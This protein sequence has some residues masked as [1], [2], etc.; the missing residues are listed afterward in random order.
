MTRI[1]G[2]DASGSLIALV[3]P[4]LLLCPL[5]FAQTPTQIADPSLRRGLSRISYRATLDGASISG[6]LEIDVEQSGKAAMLTLGQTNLQALKLMS[7]RT[8]I[9]LASDSQGNLIP[10]ISFDTD[11]I[12]GTF[13]ATGETSGQ[14]TTFAL[15]LPPAEVATLRL[16]TAPTIRVSCSNG[17]VVAESQADTESTWVIYPENPRQLKLSCT[18]SDAMPGEFRPSLQTAMTVDISSGDSGVS[19][20][21]SENGGLPEG[22]LEFALSADCLVLEARA[23][24]TQLD[25]SQDNRRLL[26]TVPDSETSSIVVRARLPLKNG[27]EVTLPF[28]KP[29]AQPGGASPQLRAGQVRLRV[30]P[31]LLVRRID[32]TGLLERDTSLAADGTLTIDM[33]PFEREPSAVI[34]LTAARPV[35]QDA[36]AVLME[37]AEEACL[38]TAW[39]NI[40]PSAGTIGQARWRIPSSW[41][42]TDLKVAG[43]GEP[44]LYR[45]VDTDSQWT[46]LHVI[47]RNP[48]TS[49]TALTLEA[50]LQNADSTA[51][52]S[53]D[54]PSFKND[55]WTRTSDFTGVTETELGRF[56][57][58][59]RPVVQPPVWMASL[60]AGTVAWFD[61]PSDQ[62]SRQRTF[63]GDAL[64]ST[65]NYSASVNSDLLVESLDLELRAG[66]QFPQQLL[67]Q[68]TSSAEIS[69]VPVDGVQPLTVTRGTIDSGV[70]TWNLTVPGE[71]RTQSELTLRMTAS[72]PLSSGRMRATLI[73]VRGAQAAGGIIQVPETSLDYSDPEKLTGSVPYPGQPLTYPLQVARRQG[74]TAAPVVSGMLFA[75]MATD[76]DGACRIESHQE[77][78]VT[79]RKDQAF[80][81]IVIPDADYLAVHVDGHPVDLNHSGGDTMIPLPTGES[82]CRI[83]LT[84]IRNSQ[85]LKT[86]AVT[87][88]LVAGAAGQTLHGLVIPPRGFTLDSTW[89]PTQREDCRAALARLVDDSAAGFRG[90]WNLAAERGGILLT[91]LT[92]PVPLPMHNRLFDA[93]VIAL[94]AMVAF[95]TCWIL[96][97]FLT[98]GLWLSTVSACAFLMLPLPSGWQ[99][100]R[101]GIIGGALVYVC[102]RS[103]T[104][105]RSVVAGIS[106]TICGICLPQVDAQLS[107]TDARNEADALVLTTHSTAILESPQSCLVKVEC[108]VASLPERQSVLRIPGN[109]PALISASLDGEDIFPV[110]TEDGLK[111]ILD[112]PSTSRLSPEQGIQANGPRSIGPWN[113]RRISYTYR[114]LP[115][116]TQVDFRVTVAQPP[117]AD[118]EFEF[119]DQSELAKRVFVEDGG[120]LREVNGKR[121]K[122]E[123]STIDRLTLIVQSA[124]A[125]AADG[126]SDRSTG[127]ICTADLRPARQRL[128]CE[129][130]RVMSQ[131]AGRNVAVG[132]SSA[133]EIMDVSS[134]DGDSLKWSVKDN[135]LAV[136]VEPSDGEQR[137]VVQ[138][139][140]N[141]ATSVQQTIP[142]G[143]LATING[144]PTAETL[145][146]P[147]TD[148][149]FYFAAVKSESEDLS[150]ELLPPGPDEP[151][152][153]GRSADLMLRV[154]KDTQAL[155]IQLAAIPGGREYLLTQTAVVHDFHVDWT[156]DAVVNLQGQP[157]FRQLVTVAGDVHI[158]EVT[159][160]SEGVSHLHSWTQDGD[161]LII[162]LRQPARAELVLQVKGVLARPTDASLSL[163]I[164]RMQGKD[165]LESDLLLSAAAG[166][167]AWIS[168]LGDA[169]P[170]ET[171][172][173]KEIP[174]QPLRFS[175]PRETR[176][177]SI[178]ESARRQVELDAVV[179][180]YEVEQDLRCAVILNVQQSGSVFDLRFRGPNGA[181]QA[182]AVQG[183]RTEPMT[184]P[185]TGLFSRQ[186]SDSEATQLVFAGVIPGMRDGDLTV[187]LPE[188]D[189]TVRVASSLVFDLRGSNPL[190]S[191]SAT[192]PDWA[193]AAAQAIGIQTVGAGMTAV[194]CGYTESPSGIRMQPSLEPAPQ[195]EAD[196]DSTFSQ[197]HHLVHCTKTGVT[198]HSAFTVFHPNSNLISIDV[199]KGGCLT[200]VR[201]NGVP[202]TI[203]S[204]ILSIS[205]PVTGTV[206]TIEV[207]WLQSLPQSLLRIRRDIDVPGVHSSRS[208]STASLIVED[209]PI[210]FGLSATQ[211]SRTNL[212]EIHTIQMRAG[213]QFATQST[214]IVGDP[215]LVRYEEEIL[216]YLA[217]ESPGA[218]AARDSFMDAATSSDALLF[219]LNDADSLSVSVLNSP[220]AEQS[221]LGGGAFLTLW[222]SLVASRQRRSAK[223]S[224]DTNTD[225]PVATP[226]S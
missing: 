134:P 97:R 52:E 151:E 197:G 132:L 176:P 195:P 148:T 39:I 57:W 84:W 47:F 215:D 194:P 11:R 124:G 34:H 206:S 135:T 56:P 142:I 14:T 165:I 223:A 111:L 203:D 163:P 31:E 213:V 3:C 170:D 199:P 21:I 60:S 125:G 112:R 81:N 137:F 78:D 175:V 157:V 19:W 202:E 10:L 7:G 220:S 93:G 13:H 32:H 156:L 117:A 83:S 119:R 168:D 116:I 71:L 106:M 139:Q 99:P 61:T 211:V 185:D 59:D 190:N 16:K 126:E 225:I 122:L 207:F 65:V 62:P 5:L 193:V 33:S 96:T 70:Y 210:W 44:T 181:T 171:L 54:I 173:D 40:Q 100:A 51:I 86:L 27:R 49:E 218:L 192:P 141:R 91:D 221:L 15:V 72:R 214:E 129:Y 4:V 105:C 101:L 133:Y 53:G 108:E 127:L 174:N 198:G 55:S 118:S 107:D 45:T 6:T 85:E 155:Q 25:F 103:R 131:A 187:Q 147:V 67:L 146:F 196:A 182:T 114:A 36:V 23:D 68:V 158:S 121:L 42:V 189:A 35:V 26:V 95:A 222:L 178:K 179:L 150:N 208:R 20:D 88:A 169:T 22:T 64:F 28:L 92:G 87:P 145:V 212:E 159:A 74:G 164:V 63:Q 191:R 167:E 205:L 209:G 153:N 136:D 29:T 69:V 37:F 73:A 120:R 24:A 50:R 8:P 183:G 149:R 77:L 184:A 58:A 82:R 17:L 80:V 172:Q 30:S 90:R 98:A 201:V 9:S 66:E 162:S 143:T 144:E 18:D 1:R 89:P 154:P 38:A 94:T 130:F 48:L 186:F 41:R 43:S 188:F 76:D 200:Q 104:S 128:T 152:A 177:L 224:P 138:L 2:A 113:I 226:E 115:Q 166:T 180:L 110:R 216:D 75:M 204:D 217:E 140:A 102:L 109:D 79:K 12:A 161:L 219:N 46:E 123:D 160:D